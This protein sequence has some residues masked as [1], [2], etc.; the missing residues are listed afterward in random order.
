[1]LF[2]KKGYIKHFFNLNNDFSTFFMNASEKNNSSNGE[3]HIHIVPIS[4]EIKE[5]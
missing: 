3:P 2:L 5:N 4:S 1:M